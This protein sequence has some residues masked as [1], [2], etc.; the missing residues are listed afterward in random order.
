MR[1]SDYLRQLRDAPS[2]I[3][4]RMTTMKPWQALELEHPDWVEGWFWPDTWMYTANTSDVAILKRA[5]Q[6]DGLPRSIKPGKGGWR[7]CRIMMRIS[8]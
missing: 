2:S 8:C 4:W 6:E 5:H 7:I 1:V 3:R